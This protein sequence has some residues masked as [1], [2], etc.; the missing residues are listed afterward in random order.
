V[1]LLRRA[2][3]ALFGWVAVALAACGPGV[4]GTGTGYG[5]EPGIAGLAWFDAQPRSVCEGPLATVA[6]CVAPA[7]GLP[8]VPGGPVRLAGACAAATLD[9]D[10]IVLDVICGGWVFAGRWGLGADS[11][12]R[13]YG[14]YGPDPMQAPTIPATLDVQS[15]AGRVIVWLRD[16][17]GDL[18]AG[19]LVLEPAGLAAFRRSE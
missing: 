4:G 14:L 18:V 9:G 6:Q 5:S 8:S 3:W 12:G 19:P 13:Y 16:S 10:E 17:H 1:N 15:D 2:G 11:V 7:V